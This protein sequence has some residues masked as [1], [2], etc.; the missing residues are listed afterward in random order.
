MTEIDTQA[1]LADLYDLRAIGRFRTGVHRPTFSAADMESRRW[2]MARAPFTEAPPRPRT[3]VPPV[4]NIRP[5][6]VA[7]PRTAP[8][9]A[10]AEP[11]E[12]PV[13]ATAP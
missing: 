13:P 1:F 9:R 12:L 10:L 3:T 2:L 5:A 8:D 6:A 11:A 7:A 4:P